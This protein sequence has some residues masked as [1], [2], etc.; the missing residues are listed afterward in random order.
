MIRNKNK[1]DVEYP[2]ISKVLFVHSSKLERSQL[3]RL[4]GFD[5]GPRK[6]FIVVNDN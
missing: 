3:Y 1:V 5:F 6:I 2:G 4:E